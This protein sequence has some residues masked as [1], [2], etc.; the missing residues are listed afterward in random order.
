VEQTVE[1]ADAWIQQAAADETR[2]E[3]GARRFALTLGRTLALALL[4]RQAQWSLDHEQ[5]RRALAAAKRYAVHGINVLADMDADEA[6][7]LARDE[8]GAVNPPPYRPSP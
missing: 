1:Q 5:S 2:L 8:S 6:R 7:L 4:A 3:A